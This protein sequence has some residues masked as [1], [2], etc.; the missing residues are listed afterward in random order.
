VAACSGDG[1][2]STG[3]SCSSCLP[4]ILSCES[5]GAR[6]RTR[7]ESPATGSGNGAAPADALHGL[8]RLSIAFSFAVAA[9]ISGRSTR[10]GRA[11]RA[12]DDRGMAFLT[13]GIAL[14]SGWRTTSS[15]GGWWFWDP[16]EKPPL[17]PG[18]WNGLIHSLRS[19]RSAELPQLDRAARDLAF[20]L[21][22]SGR[23]W[24]APAS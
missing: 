1:P 10:L 21:P 18:L 8:R 17:C 2:V 13:V 11:G 14:G 6:R 9:L 16:V 20:S 15:L 4:R 24:C 12:V 22:C 7:L 5:S 23:S 3:S 19:P